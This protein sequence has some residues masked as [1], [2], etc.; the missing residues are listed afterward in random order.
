MNN[1]VGGDL[2]VEY[3]LIL[4]D[5][6]AIALKYAQR[7]TKPHISTSQYFR[8]QNKKITKK[9]ALSFPKEELRSDQISG[10]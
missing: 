3:I 5:I 2:S 10:I 6:K 9:M 8:R 4:S 1:Y 7:L